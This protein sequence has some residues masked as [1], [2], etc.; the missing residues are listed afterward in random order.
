MSVF[1]HRIKEMLQLRPEQV[2]TVTRNTTATL[3]CSPSTSFCC[4]RTSTHKPRTS[5]FSWAPDCLKSNID[6]NRVI[7]NIDTSIF[8]TNPNLND[9]QIEVNS[10]F[11]TISEWFMVNSLSLTLSK[12]FHGK[13]F[14]RMEKYI[15]CTVMGRKRRESCRYLFRKL[16][17]LPLPSQHI[18]SLLLFVINN[19][20]QFTINSEI[21]SINSRQ[22]NNFHQPRYNLST[23][24]KGPQHS[25]TEL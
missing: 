17:I 7:V 15:T 11:N 19:R 6:T 21:H 14:Y 12:I 25:H 9:F 23:Y 8:I 4:N 2:W 20:N 18:L 22:F 3:S 24:Q 13:N 10:V 1:D 16:K 5:Y